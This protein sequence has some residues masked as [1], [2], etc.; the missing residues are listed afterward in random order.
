[1]NNDRDQTG[2]FIFKPNLFQMAELEKQGLCDSQLTDSR[3]LLNRKGSNFVN[4]APTT[5]KMAAMHWKQMVL[6]FFG[7]IIVF[8]CYGLATKFG[9]DVNPANI[10]V[11]SVQNYYPMFQDVNVMIFVGFGF[12]MTFTKHH[13]WTSVMFNFFVSTWCIQVGIL[14]IGFAHCCIEN[15]FHALELDITYLVEG[16]FA[17]GCVLISYGAVLGKINSFQLLTMATLECWVYSFNV[18]L[19]Q[20]QFKAIDMGGSMYVH[21]FGAYFGMAVAFMVGP[22]KIGENKNLGASYNSNTF[23]AIGCIFLWLFWPSFN[24]VFAT[25]NAQHR[26]VI[27]TVIS[28]CSSTMGTFAVSAMCNKGMYRMEDALNASLAGGVIIG[29]SSDIVV[30]PLAASL[31]GFFGG[32]VSTLG[33]NYLSAILYKCGIHDTCGVH[34]LHGIPGVLGGIAGA[35]GALLASTNNFGDS[36]TDVFPELWYGRTQKEQ[37]VYQFV[38]L[39]VTLGM[40]IV[41]GL[42]TGWIIRQ[43][44]FEPLD[45]DRCFDDQQIWVMEKDEWPLD[46]K[47]DE[48]EENND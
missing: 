35:I 25:G 15:K 5:K 8:V 3:H 46:M 19:G 6:F 16:L 17:A 44:F 43:P 40:A 48:M 23:A 12:L 7:Q 11:S 21:T 2:G 14:T 45:S 34:N 33:F 24:G 20:K 18:S 28:L 1:M 38:T 29:S 26:V 10:H 42:I 41:G 37:M 47:V 9:M 36:L 32:C 30:G 4:S 27:N 22:K 31:I 13:C 39:G